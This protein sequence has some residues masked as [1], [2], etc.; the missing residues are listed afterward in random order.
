MPL[1]PEAPNGV[2]TP[3]FMDFGTPMGQVP[4]RPTFGSGP[5]AAVPDDISQRI[6][7]AAPGSAPKAR[8]LGLLGRIHQQPGGSRALMA[9]GASLL[10]N[11]NFFEG[12]GQGAMAYQATLDSEADEYQPTPNKD[13]TFT[14]TRDRDTGQL[15]YE[16]TPIADWEDNR[17]QRKLDATLAQLKL[18]E[19]GDTDRLVTTLDQRETEAQRNDRFRREQLQMQDEWKTEGLESA[20]RIARIQGQNAFREAQL[21][22]G[23]TSSKP[24]P[25]GIQK[26]ISSYTD[27]RNAQDNARSQVESIIG[28]IDSGSLHFDLPSNM[29]HKAAIA[30]GIGGNA[31]TVFYGQYQTSLESLRNA[32]LVANKGVQTDGDAER[33]MAELIAGG[34]NTATI[35]A[36]LAKVVNSLRLRSGQAQARVDEL[37]RQYGADNRSSSPQSAPASAP[38]QGQTT[39]GTRWRIVN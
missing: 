7:V 35:R 18:R 38:S 3:G 25:V 14:T 26:E 37:A 30:T 29:R 39:S 28:A 2:L 15:T 22:I 16:R 10:S 31:E 19:A 34:G 27:T 4:A 5:L 6:A 20:E 33:A 32:L 24:P 12:L 13:G 8:T 11:Q 17:D 23:A 9:L 21:R 36:N 1:Y